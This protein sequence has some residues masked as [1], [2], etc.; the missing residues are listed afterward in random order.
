M[1][2]GMTVIVARALGPE[3]RGVYSVAFAV[4]AFAIQF[5]NLG[6]HAANTY[7][8]ARDRRLLPSIFG[9]SLLVGFGG[10]VGLAFFSWGIFSFWPALAPIQGAPLWIALAWIPFGIAYLL[11]QN[12]MLGIGNVRTFN[13]V[14]LVRQG[15]LLLLLAFLAWWGASSADLYLAVSL[16]TQVLVLW[17][18]VSAVLKVMEGKPRFS[19]DLFCLHVRY[20]LKAYVAAAFAFAVL[21]ADLLMVQY[22]MG[23]E[24]TGQYSIAV[25]IADLL[26]MLPVAVGTVLFP[27]L[28]AIDDEREKSLLVRRVAVMLAG[29]LLV[30]TLLLEVVSGTLVTLLFGEAYARATKATMILLPGAAL[31]GVNTVLMNYFAS[32]GMPMF[33]VYSPALALATNL[34]LNLWLI[35]LYGIEGAAMASV[36]AYGFMLVASLVYMGWKRIGHGTEICLGGDT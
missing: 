9:N 7:Y 21:R 23:S 13:R 32:M 24:S 26:T 25:A 17:L 14:E 8:I 20:G 12:I 2:V 6:L 33:T 31:L 16:A 30:A 29:V 18:I 5:G 34:F 15:M 11:V 36:A 22:F 28:C 4:A 19:L 27:R 1:G 10:G 3:G 35:P